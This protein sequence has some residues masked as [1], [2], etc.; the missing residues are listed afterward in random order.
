MTVEETHFLIKDEEEKKKLLNK[1]E[2]DEVD[3]TFSLN[4]LRIL[5]QRYLIKNDK[6]EVIE[7]PKQFSKELRLL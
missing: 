2:L 7:T 4:A 6:G 3:K 5:N 1:E